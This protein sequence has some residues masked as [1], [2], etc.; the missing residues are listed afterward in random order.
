MA[1][2]PDTLQKKFVKKYFPK[3]VQKHTLQ[4]RYNVVMNTKIKTFAININISHN[5]NNRIWHLKA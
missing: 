2:A 1:V 5:C 3:K 4:S